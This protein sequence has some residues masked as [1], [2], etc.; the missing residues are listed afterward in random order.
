MTSH[1]FAAALLLVIGLLSAFNLADYLY[2]EESNASVSYTNFTMNATAYSIVAIEGEETFLLKNGEPMTNLTRIEG[3]LYSHYV[4][5]YYPGE[6]DIE[7]LRALIKKFNDSRNDGY[8]FKGKEEYI[9][10][11]DVLLSN[12]KITVSGQP[13]RCVDNETCTKN[14][15]LLFGVYGEGLGLGSPSVIIEPLTEFT[16]ASLRLD[17][18]LSNYTLMLEEMNESNVAETLSF[19]KDTS[20]EL[21]DLADTVEATI[22]RTP[23][24]N[25]TADRK[26]CQYKCWA[27]CPSFDLDQD[28][29]KDIAELSASMESKLGPFSGYSSA[30]AGLHNRTSTRM[31]YVRQG[32][33]EV[34]Y[35]DVFS[36]LNESGTATISLAKEAL[37][38]VQNRSLQDR[39]DQLES[40]HATIPE[41]IDSHNFTSIETDLA[42][43]EALSEEVS[44][45]AGFLLGEYNQTLEAKN[46]ENSLLI[47]LES[48]DL[49]PVSLNSLEVLRN[50]TADLDA[51][52]R[53]GLSLSQLESLE[54]NYT[55]L[56]EDGQALLKTE[57]DTPATRVLLLF[58]G[59]ARRVNTGIA[60]VAEKTE[61]M[62]PSEI[63]E[64]PATLGLFSLLVF[65]SFSSM[66]LLFFLYIFSTM[67][68]TIPKTPHIL[69][70][71]FV[72]IIVLIFIFSLMM[73]LFLGK[74]STDAT[75]PEFLSDFSSRN[76]TAIFL[77]LD[78]T[79]LS[80]A[81]AMQ[82]CA[83]KLA[84]SFGDGNKTWAL[85][86]MTPNTCV[87]TDSAG[88]NATLDV[89]ECSD[90]L[91]QSESSFLLSYS[92]KN[93][94]PSFSVIY[95]SR[96]E[97]DANLAYYQSCPLVALFS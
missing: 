54:S 1:K 5:T 26:A 13:V 79:S 68:F 65:F 88:N 73:F 92:E 87:R 94:P 44:Q 19:I 41:D 48:K 80:D 70:A 6:D 50:K 9:C 29:A 28:A 59:F 56:A 47:I 38:H 58:R 78:G 18:L 43:Y 14:A 75:L 12:G 3:V 30:A 24:L 31:E 71:A 51:Q 17:G 74:T 76:D 57:S 62:P 40:L 16:P 25:D 23:R 93:Q 90:A 39:L 69:L 37:R 97:I 49:D 52:F 32:N 81:A 11:D 67:R 8:D 55:A 10:R 35:E 63:P 20:G 60:N 53:D 42:R 45:G 82:S 96:A 95:E 33:M 7:E 91:E 86:T 22:F 27:I 4:R 2:P 85:Y 89:S 34:Y 64:S 21:D 15:M 46:L 72:S 77:R 66:A 36:P 61:L 84:D 83:A